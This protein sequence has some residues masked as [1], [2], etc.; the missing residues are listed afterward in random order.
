MS[1]QRIALLGMVFALVLALT[2]ASLYCQ[3]TTA[4][5]ITGTVQDATK[6]VIADAQVTLK[7]YATG[8]V[9]TTTT[10][11]AGLYNFVAVPA[12]EYSLRVSAK[13]FQ[14]TEI[15]HVE[16]EITKVTTENIV[17][18]LGASTVTVEVV[19][20]PGAE[21]QTQDATIG[22]VLTGDALIRL[23]TQ[24]RSVTALLLLQPGVS[25]N[26]A[27][28]G[29]VNGGQVNGATVD[30]TTFYVDGGDATSDLEGT[31]SYVSPPGEPQPAPFI[32]VPA[33]WT[34]EFRVVTASPTASFARSQGGEI[35]IV[36][37]SGTNTFH[38]AAYEYYYGDG[39]SG[40]QWQ[41]DYLD[42]PKP[43]QVNNRFGGNAGGYIIKDKLYFYGGYEQR[44]LDQNTVLTNLVPT[45][46]VRNGILNLGGVSENL[47]A[48][49]G[50]LAANCG[51]A[52]TSACDPL[53]LGASP[54]MLNYLTLLPLPNNPSAGD[55][56]NSEGYTA[57]FAEPV[58]EKLGI[59]KFDYNISKNW[60]LFATYHINKYSLPTTDQYNITCATANCTT[61]ANTLIS[62]TPVQPRFVTFGLTGVVGSNFT[63]QTHGSYLRDWWRW[64]RAPLTPQLP[65]IDGVINIS[66]EG[67]FASTAPGSKQWADP[68]NF[69]TQ[70]ARSRLW[71]GKDYFIAED[72]NWVHGHH[73]FQFGSG[74]YFF[75]LIHQRDDDIL[76]GLSDGP[77]YYVGET[78]HQGGS[79][80]SIPDSQ[81]PMGLIGTTTAYRWDTMFAS[82]LGLMDR[83]A[84]IITANGNFDLNPAGVP[85]MDHVHANTFDTYWQDVWKIK[86]SVTITYGV[87]Y[88]V[89][90][91]P[92]ELNNKQV[93]L[94]YASDNQP[95]ENY[96]AY[97]DNRNAALTSGGFYASG[98]T[99]FTDST[100][101]FSPILHVPGVSSSE[102]TQ[103]NALGP[104]V[105]VAWNLPWS[106]RVF[107]NKQT[108]VRAGYSLTWNRTT[109][110]QQVLTPLLGN[111]LATVDTCAAPAFNGTNTATC[112]PGGTV[113]ATNGFRL[114][115]TVMAN[116]Y[117]GGDVP[118]PVLPSP[119]PIPLISSSPF[120]TFLSA[121]QDPKI[122]LPYSHNVTLDVQRAFANKMLLDVGVIARFTR[123]LWQDQ[124]LNASDLYAKTPACVA[125]AAGCTVT[126]AGQTLAQA[127]NA[128]NNQIR[129][130]AAV[131][132]QPFFEN[133]PYGAA[134]DTAAIAAADGG[135]PN[136]STFMLFNYDFIA[137]RP[138]DPLQNEIING[139]T[140][141]GRVNYGAMFVSFRKTFSQGLDMSAN[142]TWSHAVGTAGE[143]FLGQQ[144]IAYASPTPFDINTGIGSDN[145]DRRHVINLTLY[146][147]LPFGKGQRYLNGNNW[148]D[149]VF[150]GWYVSAIWTWET[151]LPDCVSG[152][153][154][155]GSLDGFTCAVGAS[156]FGDTDRYDN[157]NGSTVIGTVG[158]GQFGNSIGV[159][160]A[161][162]KATGGTG[163]NEFSNPGAI[164]NSLSYPLPGV[165]SRPDVETYNLPRSWNVDFGVGKRFSITE[166]VK[167]TISGEFFNVF[168]H[169]LFC[170]N[171]G[172]S[173]DLGSPAVF[174]VATGADNTARV[175]QFG[176]RIEF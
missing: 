108:V 133:A 168:N 98:L 74:Y 49:N 71:A 15:A 128:L 29:D 145:G 124:D 107:G 93:L 150:G 140:S 1:F 129:S 101:G 105:A 28:M 86:P 63:M 149:K 132:P 174:G 151:G 172:C 83:S 56:V 69:N 115:Q 31:N 65:G 148:E 77:T 123:K 35:S 44:N 68:I 119:E 166:R 138:L 111:G 160:I 121:L 51:T 159:G 106:N 134:G 60:T 38:G 125:G 92:H 147:T 36:T 175:I 82:L 144:Y 131:T 11:A 8:A 85:L 117:G 158:N 6:A 100:F 47:N 110:V 164:W 89:Q 42:I 17:L 79:A 142:W 24:Q 167:F 95:V 5:T 155:Y 62:S 50:P 3:V 55:G 27:G 10:N 80:L 37:K 67:E 154:S 163:I 22:T 4:G 13:G 59:A 90:F 141:D 157:V 9:L 34:Q 120:G 171:F 99:P 25:P 130:G 135:D 33:E 81:T 103:W 58:R 118:I 26:T 39:T 12:G 152:D 113:D 78:I 116:K 114:G 48:A 104:R 45:M 102:N 161:G 91:A 146:Y 43:H 70:N 20:A 19:S 41:L 162:N 156:Y 54:L 137:P 66:A 96:G 112:V 88:G 32:A 143:N 87:N 176:G 73:T 40:N 72:D 52:G 30:Q 23:P 94:V 64:N 97:F 46:A 136:L 153:G 84:Q 21:L 57:P 165:N 18:Q 169:P 170:I 53:G 61:G 122:H 126:T 7:S 75:N 14:V 76:G 16:A 173:T 2:P 109:E 139:A 127:Y